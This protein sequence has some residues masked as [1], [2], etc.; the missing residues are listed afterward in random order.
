MIPGSGCGA[1]IP[2]LTKSHWVKAKARNEPAAYNSF[3]IKKRNFIVI[4]G[5]ISMTF[6]R[7]AN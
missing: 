2:K 3:T 1:I 6:G 5:T 7:I 4:G